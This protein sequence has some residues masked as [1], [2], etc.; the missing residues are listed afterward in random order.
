MNTRRKLAEDDAPRLLM[1]QEGGLRPFY[2]SSPRQIK[3]HLNNGCDDVT[4][5]AHFI[6]WEKTGKEPKRKQADKPATKPS[7]AI[8]KDNLPLHIK[9]RPDNLEAVIGQAAAVK[10]LKANLKSK[11]INHSFLFTGPSGCGKTTFARILAG[12]FGCSPN[13]ILEANA[14]DTNGI[15]D[16]RKITSTLQYQGFGDNPNKMIILDECHALSKAAWQSLLKPLEEPPAHIF[17]ALCTTDDG[18]IPETIRTR[19][20]AYNLKPV[21]YDDIFDLLEIVANKEGLR[22]IDK[23]LGM[24]ARAC[25]GSPR[26]ALTMLAKVA[27]ADSDDE[28]AAL[29]EAPLENNEIIDLCRALVKGDLAW[30]K[31]TKTIKDLEAMNAESIRIVIV[32]Y[33]TSCLMG[34][35]SDKDACRLLDILAN[36]NKPYNATDKLAPLLLSFGNYVFP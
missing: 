24:I 8:E 2:C 27:E 35:K 34:A 10:S 17:F 13:N 21:K 36:F 5:Q 18:K 7:A 16:I 25:N 3:E 19:C 23:H 22:I 15:D 20:V 14:A 12:M 31:L 1:H 28:V 11:T 29:L 9:Y 6:E 30:S 4:G 33:L 32:A 26:H